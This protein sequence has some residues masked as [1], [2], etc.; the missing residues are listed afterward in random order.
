MH[1]PLSASP[2]KTAFCA[3]ILCA[4]SPFLVPYFLPTHPVKQNFAAR[5]CCVIIPF[6]GIRTYIPHHTFT[7]RTASHRTAPQPIRCTKTKS[8]LST[9]TTKFKKNQLFQTDTTSIPDYLNW[10]A[11]HL[12]HVPPPHPFN[13]HTCPKIRT[14]VLYTFHSNAPSQLSSHIH[15]LH[16]II[17]SRSHS[18]PRQ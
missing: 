13:I 1:I 9:K 4:Y 17:V 11:L 8:S 7:H 16:L 10:P 5:H 15:D 2:P 12:A 6:S 14:P 3:S 18:P